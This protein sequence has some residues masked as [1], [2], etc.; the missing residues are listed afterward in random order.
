MYIYYIHR[1][2]GTCIHI[3][4]YTDT[5]INILTYI[6]THTHILLLENDNHCGASLREHIKRCGCKT[7]VC[8]TVHTL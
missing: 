1:H 5:L 7:R 3:Y 6:F 4:I 8:A 2:T